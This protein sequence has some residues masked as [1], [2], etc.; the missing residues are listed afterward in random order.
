MLQAASVVA[1]ECCAAFVRPA[2]AAAMRVLPAAG[3]GCC[4]LRGAARPVRAAR[5]RPSGAAALRMRWVEDASLLAWPLLICYLLLCSCSEQLR[6]KSP[7]PESRTC[8]APS[9]LGEV[10]GLWYPGS[11]SCRWGPSPWYSL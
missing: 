6:L 9:L 8:S 7:I 11:R 1:G 10:A 4:G 2:S 5:A 3:G